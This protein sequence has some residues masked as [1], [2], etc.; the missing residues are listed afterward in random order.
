MDSINERDMSLETRGCSCT[1][2]SPIKPVFSCE[3]DD[4]L[5]KKTNKQ[6]KP[7]ADMKNE[8]PVRHEKLVCLHREREI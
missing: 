3:D 6:S 7:D 1:G 8:P 5:L 4:M 2:A